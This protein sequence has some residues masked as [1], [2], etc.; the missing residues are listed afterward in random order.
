MCDVCQDS[1]AVTIKHWIYC[2]YL[3]LFRA[4][5]HIFSTLNSWKQEGQV[6]EFMTKVNDLA[7]WFV[8]RNVNGK[9]T[10]RTSMMT[11]TI[12]NMTTTMI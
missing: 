11:T 5:S 1:G 9:K 10:M 12:M 8:L 2:K 4:S 3:H 6:G 7:Q